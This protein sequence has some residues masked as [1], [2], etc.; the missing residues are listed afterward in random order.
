MEHARAASI[1]AHRPIR[2]IFLYTW[3]TAGI[4]G[5][6]TEFIG[7]IGLGMAG[8]RCY[9]AYLVVSLIVQQLVFSFIDNA[10]HYF[11]DGRGKSHFFDFRN[12]DRLHECPMGGW[13]CTAA[14]REISL[15]TCIGRSAVRN[16]SWTC[17]TVVEALSRGLN[18]FY[19]LETVNA[20]PLFP[21]HVLRW[22]GGPCGRRCACLVADDIRGI[23]GIRRPKLL[24][25]HFIQRS[26]FTGPEIRVGKPLTRGSIQ[27][28]YHYY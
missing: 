16:T 2:A 1:V 22:R 13:F 9:V 15:A 18:C 11:H 14:C 12:D 19:R 8:S 28:I 26:I 20:L 23:R 27:P 25:L 4:R 24:S 21:I 3:C 5:V 17:P 6:R 7:R 10:K